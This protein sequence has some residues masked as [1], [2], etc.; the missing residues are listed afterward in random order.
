MPGLPDLINETHSRR[1][2]Y[3]DKLIILIVTSDINLTA[4][5]YHLFRSRKIV[6]LAP[7][8]NTFL[9]FLL[10]TPTRANAA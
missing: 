6:C 5:S 2:Y 4:L 10:M 1:E 7:E 3:I 8:Y 9:L